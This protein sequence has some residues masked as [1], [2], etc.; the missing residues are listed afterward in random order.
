[1]RLFGRDLSLRSPLVIQSTRPI[2]ADFP[3]DNFAKSQPREDPANLEERSIRSDPREAWLFAYPFKLQPSQVL[4]ILRQA[5]GGDLWQQSYLQALMLDSWATFRMASHKLREAAAYT[6]YTVAPYVEEEGE[7]PTKSAVQKAKDIT[8]AFRNFNPNPFTDELGMSGAI[9]DFTDAMLAGVSM[10]EM[11]WHWVQGPQGQEMTPRAACWVNPMH[12]TFAMDGAI[13][14]YRNSKDQLAVPPEMQLERN[15]PRVKQVC[16]PDRYICSQFKSK[17]GSVLGAGFMRPLAL[18]WAARQWN[19]EYCLNSAKKY[20]SP[21][22][23]ITYIPGQFTQAELAAFRNMA[24]KASSDRVLVHPQGTTAEIIPAQ[25][26]GPDNAQRYILEETD[27]ACLFLLLGQTATTMSTPG[28]LG[29]EGTHADVEDDRVIGLSNW[30]GRNPLRQLARAYMRV[31]Y[32]NEEEAPEVSPDFTKPLDSAQV[33][34]LAAAITNARIP[35]R[36]EEFY[37][38]I[39]FTEPQPKDTVLRAGEQEIMEEP[40]TATEKQ[41]I[42]MQQQMD[43]AA[44]MQEQSGQDDGQV[45]GQV[46]AHLPRTSAGLRAVLAR[47]H[48]D[49]IDQVE[50]LVIKAQAAGTGNGEWKAVAIKLGELSRTNT[51]R[52]KLHDE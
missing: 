14:I 24:Y 30:V 32:G 15:L 12:L 22:L 34:Q 42:Q 26:L 28:K 8:R 19:W 40:M 29:E 17:S 2:P 49:D 52:L 41:E 38:K 13:T 25:S 37:K 44:Q 47:A 50:K 45:S 5:M 35:V 46:D 20:G 48:K 33:A 11:I 21:F 10:T 9:Y 36:S 7:E 6:R 3:G 31:N 18:Y 51:A 39:G 23:D 16:D 27:K 4:N 43:M 1:M